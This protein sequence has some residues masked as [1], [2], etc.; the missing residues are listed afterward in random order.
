VDR[1]VDEPPGVVAVG[2]ST[3]EPEDALT[4]QIS[5]RVRHLAGLATIADGT[6][7]APGQP[8]P[9][10]DRLQE[11]GA[12]VGTGVRLVEL[13]DDRLG[14]PMDLEGAV[15]YTGCGHRASSVLCDESSCQRSFRTFQRL[16]GSLLS[17]FTHNSG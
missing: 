4:Q 2:V 13:R 16:D 3:G 10:V 17:S 9:I 5:Q 7:Q 11:N 1:V 12:A 15:R 14:N 6:G 8:Q